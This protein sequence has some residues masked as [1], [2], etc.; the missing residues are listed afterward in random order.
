MK[1][2]NDTELEDL[3]KKYSIAEKMIMDACNISKSLDAS[4]E[5]PYIEGWPISKVAVLLVDSKK[6]NC[7]L[8]FSSIT[9]GV[10]S[11]FQKD[12]DV[13]NQSS[14]GT[15]EAEYADEKRRA[16]IRKPL[17]VES[18]SDEAGFLQLAYLAVQEATGMVY[19]LNIFHADQHHSSLNNV[20]WA[21]CFFCIL[22]LCFA[23]LPTYML[24]LILIFCV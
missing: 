5:V 9:Q 20:E 7:F 1:G 24:L 10:W 18:K 6:E 21:E 19:S 17:R 16:M 14:E 22:A 23:A 8:L 2:S 11:V 13:S 4:R 3:A 15:M 12:V